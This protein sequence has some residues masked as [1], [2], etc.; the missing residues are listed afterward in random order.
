ML[1]TVTIQL[2][3]ETVHRYRRGAK[4]AKKVLEEFLVER[5]AEVAPPLA[6]DL[7]PPL[8]DELEAIEK[9]DN[10]A[11]QKLTQS[12]L[13][14]SQQRLYTHLLRKN[15]SG[16]ITTQEKETLSKLGEEAR[17]LTLKK[18]HAFMLLK[19]RGQPIPSNTDLQKPE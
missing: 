18:A 16:V 12:R 11:L 7:P 3:E 4:A 5:L 6:D 2:P 9:L 19:W 14:V 1:Q 8:R 13:P 17:L 10:E 15:S